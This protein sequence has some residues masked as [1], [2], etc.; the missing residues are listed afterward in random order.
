MLLGPATVGA[1]TLEF[2]RQN[3]DFEAEPGGAA[4]AEPERAPAKKGEKAAPAKKAEKTE[5]AA[6]KARATPAKAK[7]RK[8]G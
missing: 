4:K 7:A 5:K 3:D 2:L 1:S 6:P 8:A